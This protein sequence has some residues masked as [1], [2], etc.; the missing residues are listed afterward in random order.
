MAAKKTSK[1]TPSKAGFIRAQPH[2]MP[3]KEVVAKAAEAKMTLSEAHVHAVRSSDK[4][5]AKRKNKAA[6]STPSATTKPAKKKS[7]DKRAY[8]AAADSMDLDCSAACNACTAGA[9]CSSPSLAFYASSGCSN[10]IT[11]II[12]DS[13][14]RNEAGNQGPFASVKYT[15]TPTNVSYVASGPLTAKVTSLS[16]KT[17]C[18]AK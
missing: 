8:K 10:V 2:D 1:N 9:V 17:V 5:R 18:C 13:S 11:S 4:A 15:V 7:P 16:P 6:K 14:C 12:V 3:A